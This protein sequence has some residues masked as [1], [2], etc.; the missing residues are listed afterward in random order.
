M[1]YLLKV[2]EKEGFNISPDD[3]ILDFGCGNGSLVQT[4]REQG[5]DAYG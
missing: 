4:L 3:K 2:I 5:Y 1:H